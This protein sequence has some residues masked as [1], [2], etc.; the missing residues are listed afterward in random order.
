MADSKNNGSESDSHYDLIAIGAG[1]GGL[2]VANRAASY[3]A[4]C[5]II[6]R[7]EVL[8]GTCVNRGC[9]PKKVMWYGASM[10]QA[11]KDAEGYGY[12]VEQQG[13]DWGALVAKREEYINGINN[14]YHTYL[15]EPK[16]DV[17]S[18]HARLASPNSVQVGDDVL[19]ASHIVLAPGGAPTVPNVPGA[20]L[21]MTSDGFFELTEQP[22]KVA[23]VGAGYIAVE[24]AGM[25]R[26]FGSEVSLVLRKQRALRDFDEMLSSIL[27]EQMRSDGID[28]VS[29]IRI[30][31]LEKRD[32]KV[33]VVAEDGR[34]ISG[35]DAV[36]WAI[37]RH[38][39][40]A[41]LGLASAGLTTNAHGYI[42]V[43]KFQQTP[44]R[45][46]L[47]TR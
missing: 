29:E 14:W 37:G 1:S 23:V 2:S 24:L 36:I 39:E 13:F 16:V 11:L 32:G 31:K 22:R 30:R 26:G 3:G 9:V 33:A 43:D 4:R 34:E 12:R 44:G 10:G 38:P 5:A 25:L 42:D 6:E 20:E 15:A 7:D 17:Y 45:G 28:V 40:S 27:D 41:D 19:T 18:G 47:C 21:G 8:G 46:Y 35:C